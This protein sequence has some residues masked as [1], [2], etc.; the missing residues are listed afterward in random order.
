MTTIG[1]RTNASSHDDTLNA[2]ANPFSFSELNVT[3][4]SLDNSSLFH[5]GDIERPNTVET[6]CNTPNPSEAMFKALPDTDK[7]AAFQ[8]YLKSIDE[9]DYLTHTVF[10]IMKLSAISGANSE[11]ATVAIALYKDCYA[12]ATRTN[13]VMRVNNFFLS[14][15]GLLK[16]EDK[17]FKP[18][19]DLKACRSTIK[20]AIGEQAL[21]SEASSMFS[22]FLE[23][24]P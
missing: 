16:V 2:T 11:A 15:L 17:S 22:L 24:F 12:H 23:K 6:F 21:P 20:T 13:Q 5:V 7:V 4:S 3:A 18:V 10:A 19:Y 14:Q 9:K 1:D 8:K